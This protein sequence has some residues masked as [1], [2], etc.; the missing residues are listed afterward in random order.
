MGTK[1]D[2][3]RPCCTTREE[4]N[5]R[6]KYANGGMTFAEFETKYNILLKQ[7]LIKRNGRIV[8]C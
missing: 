1:G 2:W 4:Q 3:R 8:K 7:G 6:D 5:L